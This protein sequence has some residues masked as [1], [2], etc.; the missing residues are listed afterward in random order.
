MTA[1]TLLIGVFLFIVYPCVSTYR[2][3]AGFAGLGVDV[4]RRPQRRGHDRREGD[5]Q[6]KAEGG[7]ADEPQAD[8][9]ERCREWHADQRGQHE[10]GDEPCDGAHPQRARRACPDPRRGAPR[11]FEV[12]RG[13]PV[14]RGARVRR[15]AC[16]SCR[17]PPHTHAHVHVVHAC[18][19]AYACRRAVYTCSR[20]MVGMRARSVCMHA[21]PARLRPT[22]AQ[23]AERSAAS[24]RPRR[25]VRRAGESAAAA[26]VPSTSSSDSTAL[27][28]KEAC[29]DSPYL[30]GEGCGGA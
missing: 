22:S 18:A 9:S 11:E 21:H 4:R 3:G 2:A 25:R 24:S 23:Q 30:A 14:R 20:C 12:A 7:D 19:C 27:T 6:R 15:R 28:P 8:D 16:G 17:A 13:A 1:A 10:R 29:S 5:G 26:A